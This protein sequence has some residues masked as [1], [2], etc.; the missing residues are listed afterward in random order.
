V[1][2]TDAGDG[3]LEGQ[4]WLFESGNFEAGFLGDVEPGAGIVA[5]KCE[6]NLA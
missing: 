4:F 6:F 5:Y 1:E 3:C 2:A